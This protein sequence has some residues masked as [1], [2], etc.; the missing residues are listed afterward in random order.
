MLL[1]ANLIISLFIPVIWGII[2]SVLALQ[3]VVNVCH[4]YGIVDSPNWRKIH[5]VAVPRLGGLVFMP[6]LALSMTIGM[7]LM[8]YLEV[9]KYEAGVSTLAMITGAIM[10]YVIGIVDDF[11]EMNASMKFLI[12]LVASSFFPLCHLLINDLGGFCGIHEL[13]LWLSYPFTVFVIL[14]IVNAM[15]LIDGIDGLSSGLSVLM[16]AVLSVMYFNRGMLM[17]VLLCLSLMATLGVFFCFNVFGKAGGRKLFMGDAGS[18]TLGY[19]L[20][21]LVIKNQM[22]G[23]QDASFDINAL[24]ISYSLVI[25]PTFDVIR[26]ALARLKNGKPMFSPDKTHIHHLFMAAGMTMHQTL[27]SILSLFAILILLN[28]ASFACGISLT[29]IVV[30]DIVIYI[31]TVKV[32]QKIA[33][34]Q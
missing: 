24:L 25:I 6:S 34:E 18:L 20:A 4:R 15:N 26:V 29:W 7:A 22:K 32:M 2:F 16:L 1:S 14:L 10:V 21:Y 27:I 33:P 31:S 11:Q 12:Q 8:G 17:F 30:L 13:P 3:I 19:V 23:W 28:Y 5:K 9:N